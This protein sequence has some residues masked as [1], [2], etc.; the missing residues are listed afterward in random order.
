MTP[1]E[2][3]QRIV[4]QFMLFG[5]IHE[6]AAGDGAFRRAIFAQINHPQH[7]YKCEYSE[8]EITRGVDFYDDAVHTEHGRMIRYD[9]IITNPPF[10]LMKAGK[11]R[12]GSRKAPAVAPRQSFLERSFML[13]ANVVFYAPLIHLLGMASRNTWPRKYG[14]ELAA[15]YLTEAPD[16]FPQSGFQWCACHWT[17]RQP[18]PTALG[19][20]VLW[21]DISR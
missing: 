17:Q 19:R 10:S 9:W 8:C 13:S 15:V 11:G 1:D 21:K 3:A 18:N 14:M 20:P 2:M 5:R 12:K 4:N 6:P 16:T 7:R